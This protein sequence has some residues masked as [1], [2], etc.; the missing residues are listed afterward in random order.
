MSMPPLSYCGS[1]G[2]QM[3]VPLS[4]RPT[5]TAATCL[6]NGMSESARAAPAAQTA[7]TSASSS[8]SIERTVVM[9][10]TSFRKPS[11]NSGR[12]G[13][14]IWRADNTPCSDG[15]PSRLMYP[16]GILPA[17]YIFSS[18]SQ[19]RGK[20]SMPSR[21]FSEAVTAARTTFWSPYRTRAEPLACLASSPVS[22]VNCRPPISN[23]MDS[24]TGTPSFC[25][26]ALFVNPLGFG[27]GARLPWTRR[28]AGEPACAAN[29][30]ACLRI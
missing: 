22:I 1:V 7:S 28:S 13:R 24:G 9:I 20:K 17:A 26:F 23:E 2:L 16:P 15:R 18:K 5:R 12:I 19:V 29:V 3:S 14:S 30:R 8:G 6:S 25:L 10:W 27:P 21:G 11:G 4:S